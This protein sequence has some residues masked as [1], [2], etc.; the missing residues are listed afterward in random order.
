MYD[1]C[2]KYGNT[3]QH[4]WH[5]EDMADFIAISCYTGLRISD[6]ALF[7]IGRVQPD[8][9]VHIR[10]TKNGAWVDTWIPEW[11]Q[12]RIRTR[13]KIHGDY[14]FGKHTTTDLDVITNGWRDRL[15][16]V[17]KM[18]EPWPVKP[19]PHRFRHTFARILLQTPGIELRMVAEL[20]G[21]TVEMILKH[22]G[23]W[24][25]ERQKSITTALREAFENTPHPQH[26]RKLVAMPGGRA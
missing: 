19:E 9:A 13:A 8:G 2:P 12:E 18:C 23:A 7:H 14:I 20:M 22:Y 26:E 16:D 5:G 25:P 17:W 24:V 1:A 11:L 10:A 6:V 21:D 3:P 15:K 4:K